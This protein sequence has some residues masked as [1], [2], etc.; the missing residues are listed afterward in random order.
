MKHIWIFLIFFS[1][2]SYASDENRD[3]AKRLFEVLQMDKLLE[4]KAIAYKDQMETLLDSADISEKEL[5]ETKEIYSSVIDEVINFL[6]TKE[7]L[8]AFQQSYSETFSKQELE[9]LIKF[10][11]SPTGK[12]FLNQSG[13]LNKAFMAK[14]A[15]Q[16]TAI[17]SK[18]ETVSSNGT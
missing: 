4:N 3:T 7:V 12:K 10:Y 11:S 5:L 16:F 17:L 15:P 2:L 1:S 6:S 18:L 14:I 8:L 13:Q 9:D